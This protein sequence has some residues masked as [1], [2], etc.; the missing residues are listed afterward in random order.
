MQA[1]PHALD[2]RVSFASEREYGLADL[3]MVKSSILQSREDNPEFWVSHGDRIDQMPEGF[4]VIARTANSPIAAMGDDKHRYYGLQFH[5]EVRHT[6]SGG[7]ILKRF[8]FD[9]CG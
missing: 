2:G 1:L 9:V 8:I 6:P 4:A 3:D 7:M 5:S